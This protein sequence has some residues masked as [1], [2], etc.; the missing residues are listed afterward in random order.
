MIH[1][2]F[3]TGN[4]LK[5]RRKVRSQ[6]IVHQKI[7]AAACELRKLGRLNGMLIIKESRRHSGSGSDPV[8]FWLTFSVASSCYEQEVKPCQEVGLEIQRESLNEKCRG[9]NGFLEQ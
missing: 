2:L 5:V 8:Q 9:Q 6:V 4:P 3:I 1:C 7:V